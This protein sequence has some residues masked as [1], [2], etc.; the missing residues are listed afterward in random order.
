MEIARADGHMVAAAKPR[1]GGT[2][3]RHISMD[4]IGG[5]VKH[6]PLEIGAEGIVAGAPRLHTKQRREHFFCFYINGSKVEHGCPSRSAAHRTRLYHS[7]RQECFS[8]R[9]LK[10]RKKIM[11]FH[12]FLAIFRFLGTLAGMLLYAVELINEH[13]FVFCS[14]P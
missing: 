6:A 14:M 11:I 10:I 12:H 13:L 4:G 5:I 2:E 9:A 3:D 1:I 7:T 8:T